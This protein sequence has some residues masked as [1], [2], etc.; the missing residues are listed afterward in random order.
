[1]GVAFPGQ[2]Q[3]VSVAMGDALYFLLGK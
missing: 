1:V 3:V 2:R